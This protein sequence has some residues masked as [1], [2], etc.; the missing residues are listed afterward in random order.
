MIWMTWRAFC[1][2]P[3]LLAVRAPHEKHRSKIFNLQIW[4]LAVHINSGSTV[5][6]GSTV[7]LTR[8]F[9]PKTCAYF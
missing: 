4:K 5:H 9:R 1:A 7:Y 8:E 3:Y 2:R 6:S